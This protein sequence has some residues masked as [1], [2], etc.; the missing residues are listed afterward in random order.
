VGTKEKPLSVSSQT[1]K[2][3]VDGKSIVQVAIELDSPTDQILKLHSDYMTY[4]I[5]KRYYSY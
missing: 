2:L 5:S 1:F 3:F 4:K